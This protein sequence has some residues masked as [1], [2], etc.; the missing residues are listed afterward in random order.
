MRERPE[1]K[2]AKRTQSREG[3][4]DI[5]ASAFPSLFF[6]ALFFLGACALRL[7]KFDGNQPVMLLGLEG[8]RGPESG[9]AVAN[10]DD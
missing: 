3:N 9:G 7:L 4:R 5:Q 1:R 8:G 10:V 6:A 2:D